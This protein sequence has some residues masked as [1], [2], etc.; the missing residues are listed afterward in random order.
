MNDRS[1]PYGSRLDSV[2]MWNSNMIRKKA[3][4]EYGR[5]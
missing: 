4:E 5:E 1:F 2:L 3:E